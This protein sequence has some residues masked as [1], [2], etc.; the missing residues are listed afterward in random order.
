MTSEL[1]IEQSRI[2]Q[3]FEKTKIV[4]H[5]E[6]DAFTDIIQIPKDIR[7]KKANIFRANNR[8]PNALLV[9]RCLAATAHAIYVLKEYAPSNTLR[10]A[11]MMSWFTEWLDVY[12][13]ESNSSQLIKDFEAY[14]VDV[15]G[16]KPQG[17]GAN[18]VLYY[19]AEGLKVE[20]FSRSLNSTQKQY[21]TFLCETKLAP[22]DEKEQVT[23]TNWF[24]YHSWLRSDE[25]G[26]GNELFNRFASPKSL[27]HSFSVSI[28]ESLCEL[29]RQ[30]LELVAFFRTH[31]ISRVD[32]LIE[33]KWKSKESYCTNLRSHIVNLLLSKSG[34]R[35]NNAVK[36]IAHDFSNE[37]TESYIWEA[38]KR[39]EEV[40]TYPTVD[41]KSIHV[42]NKKWSCSLFLDI[43]SVIALC[44]Y[45][46]EAVG[47]NPIPI[48]EAENWLVTW[49]LAWQMVQPTD[50]PKL[51]ISDFRLLRR[52][53]GETTHFQIEYYKSR[54]QKE[55][56]PPMLSTASVQGTA[57]YNYLEQVTES[58]TSSSSKTPIV[59]SIPQ[60]R[61]GQ[62]STIGKLFKLLN[63]SHFKPIIENRLSKEKAS[64]TFLDAMSKLIAHGE[65]YSNWKQ[66][67]K[68]K[69]TDLS[70]EKFEAEVDTP[71]HS[72]LF[73]LSHIKNSAVHSRSDL[74]SPE[75]LVNYNSHNNKTERECY[76]TAQNE[77]WLNN[78][79]RVTRAVMQD[80]V[81]NVLRVSND[82]QFQSEFTD[83]SAI[84]SNRT[85]D[86]LSRLKVITGQERG[87]IDELGFIKNL[88]FSDDIPDVL[89]VLD[90]P[91][92]IVKYKHYLSEARSKYQQLVKSAPEFLLFTVCPTCEW[93]EE[94]FDKK[95]FSQ[96]SL[97]KGEL[98]YSKFKAHLTPLFTAQLRG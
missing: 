83:A 60:I 65:N 63:S 71:T 98:L 36:T 5:I 48:T 19:L 77:D 20:A 93:I 87:N 70:R 73:K 37:E 7:P 46:S 17:T 32:L 14:R 85:N 59:K 45:S 69:E 88:Q 12:E 57:L 54:A 8:H 78:C 74:F 66:R 28:A 25:Y 23:L 35:V 10:F 62:K 97:E 68:G 67:N 42:F 27:M 44:E 76:L 49:L 18:H 92:T 50:I 75:Q 38:F 52:A 91:E 24:G 16:T 80:L 55:H 72:T 86:V 13:I 51:S 41:G 64:P 82:E 95:R 31:N 96:S 2:A 47:T 90:S 29:Q 21:L 4:K 34:G 39:G 6:F 58:H 3:E 81:T 1:L 89:Y 84:I 15:K 94:L 26:I 33:N 9:F 30:K 43:D 79:G 61:F 40:P 53:N 22:G 11:D 56:T